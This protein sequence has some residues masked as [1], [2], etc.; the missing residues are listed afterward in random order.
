MKKTTL[1]LLLL[2]SLTAF[3]QEYPFLTASTRK[4]K[5][6]EFV[7]YLNTVPQSSHDSIF[8]AIKRY[9]DDGSLFTIAYADSVFHTNTKESVYYTTRTYV[10]TTNNQYYYILHK[11]SQE[12]L[13]AENKALK[14]RFNNDKKNRSKLKGSTIDNLT[15][16]DMQGNTYTAEQL[17]GKVVIIDFWFV[18]CA[19]CIKEMPDLNKIKEDFGTDEVAYFGITYDKKP[20]VAT[21]LSRVKYDYTVIPDSKHLTEK[22]GIEFYPTTLVIDKKGIVVYTGDFFDLKDKPENIRK[23]LKKLTS[24]KKTKI[25]A[26]PL[27]KQD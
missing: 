1:V 6:H 16:T 10:D 4:A 8:K 22:F 12:E 20:K 17:R 15:M 24:G 18:T 13:D 7:D 26:G 3:A 9:K 19:A 27:E 14:E 11:R 5:N 25:T 23:L 21:F 2:C